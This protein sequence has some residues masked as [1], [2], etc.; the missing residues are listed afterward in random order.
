MPLG[1]PVVNVGRIPVDPN[2]ACPFAIL[3]SVSTVGT[4]LKSTSSPPLT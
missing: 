3:C 4:S 1:G 2:L